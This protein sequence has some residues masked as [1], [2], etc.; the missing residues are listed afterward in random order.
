MTLQANLFSD[1][2]LTEYNGQAFGYID[3]PNIKQTIQDA[4]N[5][6]GISKAAIAG[7]MV[8][9]AHDYWEN[10]QTNDWS[11]NYARSDV[12]L[13]PFGSTLPPSEKRSSGRCR[14][15][16][17]WASAPISNGSTNMPRSRPLPTTTMT[18][19]TRFSIQPGR[20]GI[21]SCPTRRWLWP[22]S[23]RAGNTCPTYATCLAK[24]D[25]FPRLRLLTV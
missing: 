2:S 22:G 9:E 24:Q 15:R 23:R 1:S 8:E 20:S 21:Y 19:W 3:Q 10:Q 16:N 6:L 12:D 11:D 4:A 5:F 18:S 17:R 25:G 7:A 14:G 13:S